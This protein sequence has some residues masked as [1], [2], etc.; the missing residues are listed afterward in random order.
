MQAGRSRFSIS[1]VTPQVIRGQRRHPGLSALIG[2]DAH[3]LAKG[4]PGDA[5]E[6]QTVRRLSPPVKHAAMAGLQ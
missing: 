3:R 4:I 1:T 6:A 5:T 2:P